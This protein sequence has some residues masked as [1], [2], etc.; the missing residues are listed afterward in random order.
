M[1]Y[2]RCYSAEDFRA[3][4]TH[5]MILALHY[6]MF[7]AENEDRHALLPR[8]EVNRLVQLQIPEFSRIAELE[9][10]ADRPDMIRVA[11]EAF[12][13]KAPNLRMRVRSSL[14]AG[15]EWQRHIERFAPALARAVLEFCTDIAHSNRDLMRG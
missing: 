11:S 1:S 5:Y 15:T 7:S 2:V 6:A 3:E 9:D 12:V 13:Q 4:L 8:R 10:D 14:K